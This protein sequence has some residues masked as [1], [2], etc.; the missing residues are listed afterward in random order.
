MCAR[1]HDLL[2]AECG[3]PCC[4]WAHQSNQIKSNTM[5]VPEYPV[6]MACNSDSGWTVQQAQS[7]VI[8]CCSQSPSVPHHRHSGCHP[9][10]STAANTG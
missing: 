3:V 7:R 8:R 5:N 9:C 2:T 10:T 6:A 1:G 4:N